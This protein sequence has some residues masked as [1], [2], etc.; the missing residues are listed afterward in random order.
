[1]MEKILDKTLA[2]VRKGALKEASGEINLILVETE[3]IKKL[4]NHYR[5]KEESTDVLSFPQ[6]T[7][8]DFVNLEYPCD[9]Y[10]VLGDIVINA[11]AITEQAEEYGHSQDREMGFLFTHGLLHL[12][13][14]DHGELKNSEDQTDMFDLQSK[15]LSDLNITRQ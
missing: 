10:M 3:K 9:D 15:I 2:E 6:M 4:N 8:E 7:D 14:Y 13:G 11:K 1:M 12:L 5:G